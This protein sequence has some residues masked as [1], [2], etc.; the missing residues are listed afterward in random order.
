MGAIMIENFSR[1]IFK[2]MKITIDMNIETS[3]HWHMNIRICMKMLLKMV[4]SLLNHKTFVD[5]A[6]EEIELQGD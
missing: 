3:M 2:M 1:Y 4:E 6:S 5:R